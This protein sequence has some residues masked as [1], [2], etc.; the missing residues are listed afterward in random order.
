MNFPY[1]YSGGGYFRRT[2]VSKGVTAPILHGM[3]AIERAVAS[4]RISY[5]GGLP[6]YR[7][8]FLTEQVINGKEIW[9]A[10]PDYMP[11]EVFCETDSL[12]ECLR[13]VDEGYDFHGQ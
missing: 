3:Q 7:D 11:S 2:G 9:K 4:T 12:V 5:E 13:R 10:F 8:Y 6:K 1:E